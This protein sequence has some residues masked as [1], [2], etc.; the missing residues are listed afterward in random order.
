M[1]SKLREVPFSF[2]W[3]GEWEIEQSMVS[4]GHWYDM[5]EEHKGVLIY[6]EH[7]YYGQSVPTT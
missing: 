4:G 7:R 1:S 5:A 2:T 3:G 6:T